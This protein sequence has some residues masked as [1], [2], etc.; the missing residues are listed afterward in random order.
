[1]LVR[2]DGLASRFQTT[3]VF[4]NP[5]PARKEKGQPDCGGVSSTGPPCSRL[6]R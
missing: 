6:M 3:A 1:M 5:Y 4:S 2:W